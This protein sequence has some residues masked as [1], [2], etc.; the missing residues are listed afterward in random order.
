M[1]DA[2]DFDRALF[3]AELDAQPWASYTHAYGSA[4]DV[5]G[6][7][8]ALAGDDDPAAEEAQSELYGS[9]LH[10]GSV[11]EA[12]AMAVPFLARIAAAGIRTVDVLLLI[13]GVAEGGTDPGPGAEPAGG[14]AAG[15]SDEAACRRAVVAQLP[16]LLASVE[17]QD[18]A[19]RQAAAWAAGWTGTAGAAL[20]VPALRERA[21]VETDPLVRAE[22]LTSLVELDPEGAA[23]AAARAV[24]P[25]SPPELRIAAV[26]ACVDAGLPWTRDQH[27]AVLDLLPLDRL[28]ADRH[29]HS[30][31]EPLHA[32]SLALLERDTEADREAVFALLDA[33]LRSD[34]PEART[35]AVW[36]ATTACELSRSAPARLAPALISAALADGPDDE[37]GALSAL[38]RLGPSG[39]PAADLL[40]ARAAG[41]GDTADRALEALVTVDPVRAAPLL[42]RDLERRPRALQA[43]SGGLAEALPVVPFD[44]ELL[45]AV[46]RRLATMEP[47]GTTPF[48][49]T[50]LLA[51]WGPDASAAVPELLAALPTHPR[52]LPKA[53]VAVCPPGRRAEAADA[54]LART[55]TGPA[56]ERIEAARALHELAGDHGPLLPLLAERLAVSAGGGGGSGGSIREAAE[57]AAAVGPAASSLVPALR[58]ALNS[59]G[60]ERTN[61][62]MDDDIA[63]AVALH[64]ITGDAVEAVPV[65]A[66]VL[67]DRG[68]LWRRWTL[69]RAAEAAGG[70]GPAGRPLVPVLKALL[71]DLRQTPSVALALHAVAPDALD[72]GH[73]AGLLL[74]AAEASTAP[75]E[76][77]DALV[78]FGTDALSDEHRARLTALGERDRRVVRSGLDGTV[79]L[80]DERLRARVRAAVR[81]A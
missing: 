46:R 45:A 69:V 9:I 49:L 10:Q 22:L 79:E 26:M 25:D 54:L 14:G 59:P 43:A 50:A 57:A 13:G 42:A 65:L 3:H 20:A 53:L 48:R 15:E 32:I 23:P 55:G 5:P 33:A 52:V 73:V 74:D 24:G 56:E 81:G 19:V 58:A 35:E 6:C 75:F 71:A 70:L 31:N 18:R 39:A 36:A 34:D 8:R 78:V 41:D 21:A 4:E 67:G 7:L 68:G 29:D 61:P 76:A 62:Q 47:G 12:S 11:Y 72:A 40:A 17:H 37:T 44:P 28:A 2:M 30:R 16:L 38:G 63:L 1:I 51:S 60:A 27:E 80:T 77:V 66:G 64:Q